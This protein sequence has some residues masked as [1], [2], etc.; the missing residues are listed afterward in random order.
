M[1]EV[2]NEVDDV[3][4]GNFKVFGERGEMLILYT[5]EHVV[6]IWD[7]KPF[8]KTT[9]VDGDTL[10]LLYQLKLAGSPEAVHN[11]AILDGSG[12]AYKI[13]MIV[14]HG[15][16]YLLQVH[17]LEYGETTSTCTQEVLLPDY[18]A[19]TQFIIKV[20][21][22]FMCLGSNTGFVI[23]YAKHDGKITNANEHDELH[24]THKK[25]L[26]QFSKRIPNLDTQVVMIQTSCNVDGTPIFDLMDGWLVYS[27]TKDE[28]KHLNA[29]NNAKTTRLV[30]VFD[31]PLLTNKKNTETKKPQ[32]K[33]SSFYTPV[34]LPPS[35]PLLNKVL[36]T[37]SNI[38]V[39]GIFKLSKMS[40]SKVHSY[41]KNRKEREGA[42]TTENSMGSVDKTINTLGKTMG[43]LLY[44]TA[45]TT[46]TTLHNSTNYRKPNSNQLI[47]VIDLCNDKDLGLI[48]PPG[49]VSAV[50]LSPYDLNLVHATYRGDALY[51]W[52]MYRLPLE[53][54]LLGKFRR[55]KTLGVIQEIFWFVNDFKEDVVSLDDHP[56]YAASDSPKSNT[57]SGFGGSVG[58]N[59]GF[60]CITRATG[61]IHWFNVN[62]LS[63]NL[64]DNLPKTIGNKGVYA[65]GFLDSWILP[66]FNGKMFVGLPLTCSQA[67]GKANQ[68]AVL[69]GKDQ[70][71][72]ISTLNGRNYYKFDIP[73]Q[74]V[75]SKYV[76]KDVGDDYNGGTFI[77]NISNNTN[78][79]VNGGGQLNS[80][81]KG[82]S[83]GFLKSNG[84]WSLDGPVNANGNGNG[85]VDGINGA[86]M[87][88][89]ETDHNRDC[90][91]PLSNA[92]IETCAPFLNLFNNR[93]TL[94]TYLIEG[95]ECQEFYNMFEVFGNEIP[96]KRLEFEKTVLANAQ[97][98]DKM[99]KSDEINPLVSVD[100][101]VLNEILED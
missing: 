87:N 76:P 42:E 92:E 25:A 35:G 56:D 7:W 40:S 26:Q 55:G 43:K 30:P 68:L 49:G 15:G 41:F 63:G 79:F 50:S 91:N 73:A 32:V 97:G 84:Y 95:D 86:S 62:Y 33:T 5:Q 1:V 44:S 65:E 58:C 89:N 53:F 39:D 72:M 36:S 28:F 96:T 71:K 66:S 51:M 70:L 21:A 83:N 75:S 67:N 34:K 99:S 48:K 38:A 100:P 13:L 23:V 17:S 88:V 78:G 12:P 3:D 52:D 60:G 29:V 59:S 74:P 47:K 93:I 61:S 14:L 82:K 18:F 37:F 69:D 90:G 46:A 98:L 24:S 19:G 9:K 101:E 11:F 54:S 6:E 85:N 16:Q 22:K 2:S 80:N 27:P 94:E 31:D 8:S 20:S 45:T 64:T 10:Y 57:K 81:G 77:H 4:S